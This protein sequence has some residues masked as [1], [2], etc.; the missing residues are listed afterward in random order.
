[1]SQS[2]TQKVQTVQYQDLTVA[3]QG[4]PVVLAPN[5]AAG[6]RV[7]G[8]APATVEETTGLAASTGEATGLPPLVH[9]V[10]DPVDAG[11]LTDGLARGVYEDDL[12]VLEQ[13]I[14]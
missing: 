11:V 9:G 4:D 6:G 2:T 3:A 10:D 12:V 14:L 13:G 7:L 5:S 8:E 1:M